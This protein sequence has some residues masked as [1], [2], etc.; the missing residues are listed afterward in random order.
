VAAGTELLFNP[1]ERR[2]ELVVVV[3]AVVGVG[4]TAIRQRNRTLVQ[5]DAFPWFD[6]TFPATD[7]SPHSALSARPAHCPRFEGPLLTDSPEAGFNPGPL[8]PSRLGNGKSVAAG[9]QSAR[10]ERRERQPQF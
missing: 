6:W 7:W 4:S 3:L 10:R 1:A 9:F 8:R 5:A 2:A